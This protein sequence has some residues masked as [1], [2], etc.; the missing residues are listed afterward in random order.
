[1][2]PIRSL[3][4]AAILALALPAGPAAAAMLN[5]DVTVQG[6]KVFLTDL[7]DGLEAGQDRAVLNAPRPGETSRVTAA[8]L[9]RLAKTAGVDWAPSSGYEEVRILRASI[10]V[11]AAEIA[12]LMRPELTAQIGASDVEVR[13]DNPRLELNLPTLDQPDLHLEGLQV[14]PRT[15]RFSANLAGAAL[16]GQRIPISGQAIAVRMV[17][18]L[19][20]RLLKGQVI[21]PQDISWVNMRENQL[22]PDVI[23]DVDGLIGMAAR[24]AVSPQVPIRKI[25]VATPL[26]VKRNEIVVMRY[27]A[28]GM[29]LTAKGRVQESAGIGDVVNVINSESKRVIQAIV[30][31]PQ[32]VDVESGMQ[33]ASR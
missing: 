11:S 21:G 12:E 22:S 30:V 7:F 4:T 10:K 29:L 31:G 26:V 5:T 16:A 27:R 28:G 20:T 17:P 2:L 24:R 1:M 8:T 23:E 18:V 3:I 32:L 14:Q 6:N 19:N 25:D 9:A 33:V 15:G 13:L